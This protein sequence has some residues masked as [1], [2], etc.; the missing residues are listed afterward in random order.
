MVH[1]DGRTLKPLLDFLGVRS[2]DVDLRKCTD[3][4][5]CTAK[6]SKRGPASAIVNEEEFRYAFRYALHGPWDQSSPIGEPNLSSIATTL[7]RPCGQIAD[8]R[9]ATS[10][11]KFLGVVA[12]SFPGRHSPCDQL[13]RAPFLGNYWDLR[14]KLGIPWCD[15][16]NRGITLNFGDIDRRTFWNSEAA[17]QA[18]KFHAMYGLSGNDS[19][20]N[21]SFAK[22]LKKFERSSGEEAFALRSELLK[23]AAAGA[24]SIA[25]NDK[26]KAM[27]TVLREKF[28]QG[29]E[30][31]VKLLETRDSFLLEHTSTQGRDLLWSDNMDGTGAN[32]LGF[33][34]MLIRDELRERKAK[35]SSQTLTGS[36]GWTAFL[37]DPCGQRWQRMVCEASQLVLKKLNRFKL[38]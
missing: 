18:L 33:Q 34:L 25:E 9:E 19:A 38:Q 14:Q 26:K 6:Q 32:W 8:L 7:P 28:A 3:A 1:R 17:Y 5:L 16:P 21:S 36:L 30:L 23:T 15:S 27:L 12:F 2:D 22:T 10:T 20:P 11:G 35:A 24:E 4:T 29:S 31:A 37:R 13:C